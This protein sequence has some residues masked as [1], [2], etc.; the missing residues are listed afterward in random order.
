MK[1]AGIPVRENLLTS[2]R[3]KVC[4][5]YNPFWI[6]SLNIYPLH[7]RAP[8]NGNWSPCLPFR[9]LTLMSAGILLSTGSSMKRREE[10]SAHTTKALCKV[11]LNR[12]H[13][14]HNHQN[15]PYNERVCR[16]DIFLLK[17]PRQNISIPSSVQYLKHQVIRFFP[18][19]NKPYHI[20]LPVEYPPSQYHLPNCIQLK[21]LTPRS[22]LRP[23]YKRREQE[24]T[25]KVGWKTARLTSLEFYRINWFGDRL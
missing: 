3:W 17:R 24:R 15:E 1:R 10:T 8:S 18:Q 4:V 20:S 6:F 25:Q 23:W 16:V 5:C 14:S 9:K 19:L 13:S 11:F 12:I 21:L 22:P 2:S 7:S